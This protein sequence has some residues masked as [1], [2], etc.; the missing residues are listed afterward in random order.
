MYFSVLGKNYWTICTKVFVYYFI[1]DF[2]GLL[3]L[4]LCMFCKGGMFSFSVNISVTYLDVVAIGQHSVCRLPQSYQ[5]GEG[6]G[7]LYFQLK[8]VVEKYRIPEKKERT[9]VD[10][11]GKTKT[12]KF[13]TFTWEKLD[14][15]KEVKKAF[16]L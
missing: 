6:L 5:I 9:F 14:K 7:A 8:G 15:V 13:E 16:N 1:L 2:S 3:A 4:I 10:G 11:S 12:I